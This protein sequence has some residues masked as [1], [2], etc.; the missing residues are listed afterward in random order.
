MKPNPVA[1]AAPVN[2]RATRAL[3]LTFAVLLLAGCGSAAATGTADEG[4][5]SAASPAAAPTPAS[6]EPATS[7]VATATVTT[8]VRP[9]PAPAASTFS[10]DVTAAVQAALGLYEKVPRNPQDASAGYV[11]GPA[12]DTTGHLSPAVTARLDALRGSGY[13]GDRVC[14]EDYLTGTQNGLLAAPTVLSAHEDPGG[15]VTV[16]IRRPATPAPPDLTVVMTH[17]NGV[18]LASDL[19]SGSGPSA[20]I[21]ATKPH[22]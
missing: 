15:T 12:S 11:W 19:A 9:T 7:S 18:W 17:R 21:F 6:L 2:P 8:A 4:S 13:F 14:A 22:C 20:S 5:P 1:T 10:G 3:V 16:V